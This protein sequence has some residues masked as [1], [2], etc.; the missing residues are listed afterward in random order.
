MEFVFGLL[1]A[2]NS[3]FQKINN[4][5]SVNFSDIKMLF[6]AY[7]PINFYFYLAILIIKIN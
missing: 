7:I 4:L 1:V 2:I 6:I 5:P 3:I